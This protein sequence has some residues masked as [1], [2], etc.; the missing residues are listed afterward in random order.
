MFAV[1]GDTLIED[2]IMELVRIQKLFCLQP[3]G[4]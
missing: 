3:L 1:A 2:A 4:E